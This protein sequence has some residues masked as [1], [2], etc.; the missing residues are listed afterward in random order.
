MLS[1][2]LFAMAVA[3]TPRVGRPLPDDAATKTL[4][5]RMVSADARVES[6]GYRLATANAS[7]CPNRVSMIG[8]RLQSTARYAQP[9]RAALGSNSPIFVEAV[10]T[11]SPA[12]TAGLLPGDGVRAIEDR[13][14]FG[15]AAPGSTPPTADALDA[16]YAKLFAPPPAG[17]ITLSV[18]RG[19]DQHRYTIRGTPACRSRFELVLGKSYI[20]DSDGE[21]IRIGAGFVERLADDRLAAVMAHELAHNILAHP[22]RRAREGVA[23]GVFAEFGRSARL[24]LAMEDEADRLSLR[25]LARAGYDPHAAVDLWRQ[26]GA[27]ISG[28]LPRGASHRGVKSRADL[29]EKELST[30]DKGLP[31]P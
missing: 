25:L 5:A 7:L 6:I 30:W 8:V 23:S 18:Q 10:V 14:V 22:A 29:I 1:Y 11:G 15:T 4:I 20:A 3:T 21:T 24:I 31:S 2:L 16:A 13:D 27:A 28:F 26:D 9:Y 17:L 12:A 19:A